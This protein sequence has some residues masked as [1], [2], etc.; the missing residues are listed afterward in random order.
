MPW[1]TATNLLESSGPDK[2]CQETVGDFSASRVDAGG[3]LC[4]HVSMDRLAFVREGVL[5]C[6]EPESVRLSPADIF[7]VLLLWGPSERHSWRGWVT[8]MD[9]R[10]AAFLS[11]DLADPEIH[12]WLTGLPAWQSGELTRALEHPGLHQVW[13]RRMP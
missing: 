5:W 3:E 9:R 4:C 6:S 10:S 8:T 1:W 7:S 12:Y 11:A 2:L 13:R